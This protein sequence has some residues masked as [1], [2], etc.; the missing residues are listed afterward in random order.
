[1]VDEVA[2]RGRGLTHYIRYTGEGEPLLHPHGYDLIEYAARHSGVFVTLTTN[3]TIMNEKR[4]QRLLECGVHLIDISIDALTPE[5]YAKIRVNGKLE[6]TRANVLRLIEWVGNARSTTRVVVSSIDACA[7]RISRTT[8]AL[9]RSAVS[10]PTGEGPGGRTRDAA[11]PTWSKS[12]S[13]DDTDP[14]LEALDHRRRPGSGARGPRVTD[15]RSGRASARI[16]GHAR[17][18]GRRR[19]ERG[20]R[21]RFGRPRPGA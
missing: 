10:V 20:G 12:S 6:E 7:R 1:M 4:T 5:T 18:V 3:G 9:T 2:L 16:R 14:A 21:Q 13:A 19:G 11:T 8:S 15:D 17:G